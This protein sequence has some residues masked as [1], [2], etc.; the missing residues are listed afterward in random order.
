M[1]ETIKRKAFLW[2]G[3]V[4]VCAAAAI[5]FH[6]VLRH[7]FSYDYFDLKNLGEQVEKELFSDPRLKDQAKEEALRKVFRR[8]LAENKGIKFAGLAAKEKNGLSFFL[9]EGTDYANEEIFSTSE[10]IF[11]YPIKAGENQYIL[12]VAVDQAELEKRNLNLN[13]LNSLLTVF[14]V[15]FLALF[16]AADLWR[17]KR[18]QMEVYLQRAKEEKEKIFQVYRDVIYSVTQGKFNLVTFAETLP[19]AKE[20]RLEQ[21]ITLRKAEDVGRARNC[22]EKILDKCKFS[23]KRRTQIMLCISEA[24][25]N[26]VKHAGGGLF[27]LRLIGENI[28]IIISDSGPG[29]DFDRLPNMIFLKGFSTKVSMGYGFSIIYMLA[30]KIYLATSREGTFLAM[31]FHCEEDRQNNWLPK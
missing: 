15:T 14:L 13:L 30:D 20:G 5:V 7:Y 12:V 29:M 18:R 3:V 6:Y 25:T 4:L 24:A 23:P 11:S 17:E 16:F 27:Q 19:L 31:D 8:F 2:V 10:L 22:A 28:R 1:A 9:S 21:E 26:A